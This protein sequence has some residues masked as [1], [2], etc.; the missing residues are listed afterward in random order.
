MPSSIIGDVAPKTTD[1]KQIVLMNLFPGH[2][3]TNFVGCGDDI[4]N[5]VRFGGPLFKLTKSSAGATTLAWQYK[6][7]IYLAGGRCYYENAVFGDYVD[8][9]ILAPATAG[10]AA[11]GTGAYNKYQ[12]AAGLNMFVPAP[13]VDGDWDLNL[14]EKLNANVDFTKVVPV[15][16]SDE[17]GFFDWDPET[18]AVTF[19]AMQTGKY[20]LFD[21]Q[22]T[23]ANFVRKAPVVGDR[24]LQMVVPAVKPKRILAH[25]KTEVSITNA[26][27]G[28]DLN[29]CWYMYLAR[30][31]IGD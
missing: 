9:R 12:V 25:W 23:I 7:W 8:C 29:V 5:N 14:T 16:S 18:E 6:E 10:T 28:H 1:G 31:S 17:T 15:P 22:I 21:Q 20:N 24:D 13:A 3:L 4:A 11:S 19:N 2:V 26:A 27:G 30:A